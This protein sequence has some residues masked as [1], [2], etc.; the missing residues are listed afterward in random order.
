MC[1]RDRYQDD[2]GSS[3]VFYSKDT[4]SLNIKSIVNAVDFTVSYIFN[5]NPVEANQYKHTV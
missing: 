4:S 1:I 2:F 5:D 3:V